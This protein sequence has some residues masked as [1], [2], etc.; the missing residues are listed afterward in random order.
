MTPKIPLRLA[1]ASA[2]TVLLAA[3]ALAQQ[4][5]A[6]QSPAMQHGQGGMEHSQG[7]IQHKMPE[8]PASQ[9][10]MESMD[11]MNRDMMAS[12]MTGDADHDFASMMRAHHQSAVDMAKVQLRYGKDPEMRK[13]AE[14]IIEDQNREIQQFDRWL[15]RHP[16]QQAAR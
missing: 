16:P 8:T 3:P 13:L 12:P 15:E 10:Y 14:K 11:K 6:H 9:A 2:L 1:A 5:P 7:S 4:T